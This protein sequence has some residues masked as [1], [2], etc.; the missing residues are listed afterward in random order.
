MNQQI[1][2][3]LIGI[4]PR[5]GGYVAVVI[6]EP[7]KQYPK[8]L[9]TKLPNLIQQAQQ[10][11]NQIV[12][13]AYSEWE[14]NQINPHTGQPYQ[15]RTL[16][17]LAMGQVDL[18]GMPTQIQPAQYMPPQPAPPQPQY[19]P[20]QPQLQPQPVV[21]LTEKKIHRQTATKVAVGLLAYLE[22]QDQNL[23]SL[24]RISEQLVQYYDNGVQWQ[25]NPVQPA[26]TQQTQPQ[27]QQVPG[28]G[29]Q[30]YENPNEYGGYAPNPD[31][32]I[33]F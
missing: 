9:S 13:G 5:N 4:E 10:M 25:T 26:E 21:N 7:G 1:T 27:Q 2:G 30:G 19:T 28:G 12:T 8:K 3:Q 20:P 17:A 15:N 29:A 31:D 6:L 32:D 24:V 23:A 33:P 18:V 22:P 11:I 14:S 16:E